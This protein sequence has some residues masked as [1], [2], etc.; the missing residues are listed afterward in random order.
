MGNRTGGDVDGGPAGIEERCA[1]TYRAGEAAFFVEP[2][3]HRVLG[4]AALLPPSSSLA[5]PF[6]GRNTL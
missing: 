1:S 5:A 6:R 3:K 2:D 4:E